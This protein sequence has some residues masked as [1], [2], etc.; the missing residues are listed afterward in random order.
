MEETIRICIEDGEWEPQTGG[1]EEPRAGPSHEPEPSPGLQYTIRKKS[2]RAYAKN[3][4]VDR[5]YQVKVDEQ[6]SGEKLKDIIG[7]LHRMF[8]DI[9]D[10]ARGDLAGNDLGRVVIHHEGLQDPIIVPLQ[11]WDNL[12]A[13]A[14]MGTI[15]KVLNSKQDLPVNESF[16]ITIGSI[17]LPKGSGRRRQITRLTGKDNSLYLKKSIVTI[18]N[19]DNLCMARA[20]GVAWAKLHRCT[21]DEW[22]TITQQ[23][24]T[25]SNLELILQH[26]KVPESYYKKL[27]TKNRREQKELAIVISRLAGVPLDRPASL[28]DIAAFEEALD[29]RVMVVSA[30]LGE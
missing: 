21:Q 7:G 17:D 12:D 30:R 28:N 26:K 24:G 19:D 9:L 27:R 10:Q 14:V 13:D 25:K 11:P 8:D 1:G 18:E 22:K 15:E 16:E 2:E 29:V 4:A 3:A 6:H 23:R 5:T 20:I